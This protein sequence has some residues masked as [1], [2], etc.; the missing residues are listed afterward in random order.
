M[1]RDARTQSRSSTAVRSGS[2]CARWMRITQALLSASGNNLGRPRQQFAEPNEPTQAFVLVL[3]RP[4]SKT[5]IIFWRDAGRCHYGDQLWVR[6]HATNSGRCAL[7]QQVI[8]RGDKVYKPR[9]NRTSPSNAFCMILANLIELIPREV[10]G[11][12]R[13]SY[14][15]EHGS[16]NTEALGGGFV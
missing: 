3:E 15:K 11:S 2:D 16:A 12:V 9:R 4:T 6:G 1:S 10:D 14:R 5:A 7:S 8:S 13:D